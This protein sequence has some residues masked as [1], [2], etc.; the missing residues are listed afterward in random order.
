MLV[1]HSTERTNECRHLLKEGRGKVGACVCVSVGKDK[2]KKPQE[3]NRSSGGWSRMKCIIT[4][5][6][7]NEDDTSH[8]LCLADTFIATQKVL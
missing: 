1:A 8:R 4:Y 5:F 3:A 2:T 6:Y 7:L